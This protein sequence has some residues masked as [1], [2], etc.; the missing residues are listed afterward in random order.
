MRLVVVVGADIHD[1]AGETGG[2]Y[3]YAGEFDND[4]LHGLVFLNVVMVKGREMLPA[5]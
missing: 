5:S 4:G 1:A 2:Q 3:Q